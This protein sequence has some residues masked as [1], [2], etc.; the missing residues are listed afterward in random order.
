MQIVMMVVV[1]EQRRDRQLRNQGKGI[2]WRARSFVFGRL[3]G[4]G[5]VG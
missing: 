1:V 3:H 2:V 5:E 4:G